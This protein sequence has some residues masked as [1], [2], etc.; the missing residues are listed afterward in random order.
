M[1]SHTPPRIFDPH[2]RMAVRRRMLRTQKMLDAPRY[3]LDDMIEDVLE[4]LAFLRHQPERA[5]VI[6]DVGGVLGGRLESGG[7]QVTSVEPG[8]GFDEEAPLPDNDLGLVVSLGTLDTV[9]DL[10]GAL[11]HMRSALSIGGL[12]IASFPGAGS[13]P[14]LRSAMLVADGE[15]PAPRI[16]PLVDVRAGA[17]LVQRTGFADPVADSRHLD[18]GFRSF[19]RAIEDLRAQGH[20]NVLAERGAPLGRAA[21][22]LAEQA[23]RAAAVDGR[24]VERFEILTLSGWRR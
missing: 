1:A 4:R 6:G 11:V 13:L 24:T 23:Y 3:L 8:H 19:A 20:T 18:V 15:R 14:A 22:A 10:P 21:R 7:T 12:M 17:Q 16:H 9:N 5:L 2:R